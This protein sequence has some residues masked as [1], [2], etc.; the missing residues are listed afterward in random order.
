MR[1]LE[2]KMYVNIGLIE[3]AANWHPSSQQEEIIARQETQLTE[4][5]SHETELQRK[6]SFQRLTSRPSV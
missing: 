3:N 5:E 1:D 4:Y 6:V 2:T